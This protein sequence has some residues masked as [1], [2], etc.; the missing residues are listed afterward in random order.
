MKSMPGPGDF[1]TWGGRTY[2]FDA[3]DEMRVSLPLWL[4][5]RIKSELDDAGEDGL[6]RMVSDSIAMA[7]KEQE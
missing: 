7:R 3:S 1:Q 6:A 5:R 4:A 2:D